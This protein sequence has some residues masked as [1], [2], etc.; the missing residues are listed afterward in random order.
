MVD[1]MIKLFGVIVV[2]GF[3]IYLAIKMMKLQMNVVEGLTNPTSSVNGEAG[4]ATD[5]ASTLKNK[6][7][8]LQDTLLITKYRKDY[9]NVILSMDDYI[10][11]LMLKTT[12]N[13]NP[14]TDDVS[15]NLN[16]IQT[17]NI[18]NES[19]ASLNNVMKY[20]DKT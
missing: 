8:H 5:Y 14:N 9:E 3:L 7:T 17:L 4:S 16:L 2:I 15:V 12:L 18:L 6:V 19:K 1:E 11:A 10:N 20:V 13:I